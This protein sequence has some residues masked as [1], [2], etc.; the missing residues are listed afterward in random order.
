ME[1][2]ADFLF[3]P[4]F[5]LA[6]RATKVSATDDVSFDPQELFMRCCNYFG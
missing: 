5:K 4:G 1:E 6:Y 3:A 2:A